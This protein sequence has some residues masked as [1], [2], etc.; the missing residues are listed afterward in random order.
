MHSGQFTVASATTASA[1]AVASKALKRAAKADIPTLARTTLV[2]ALSSKNLQ[3]RL[4]AA[5]LV[6]QDIGLSRTGTT[7]DTNLTSSFDLLADPSS[8][9]VDPSSQKAPPAPIE[10]TSPDIKF[11]GDSPQVA[12]PRQLNLFDAVEDAEPSRD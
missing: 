10:R 12:D 5:A 6:I 11:S 2:D 3:V 7:S 4:R 9:V 8:L 1:K